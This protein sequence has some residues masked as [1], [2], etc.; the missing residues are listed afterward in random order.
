MLKYNPYLFKLMQSL[1]YPAV[2][3]TF[4]VLFIG[5][6]KIMTNEPWTFLQLNFLYSV[7]LI[8]YF[9]TSFLVNENLSSYKCYN[10]A[11][12]L[13]DFTEIIL[14]FLCFNYLKIENGF[15]SNYSLKYFYLT[16]SLIPFIQ[17]L[18]NISLG[19]TDR[20]YIF[21]DILGILLFLLAGLWLFK[22][23]IFNYLFLF[24]VV[25]LLT[26]YL[27]YLIKVDN[28]WKE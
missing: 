2:L 4:F 28:D 27:Y 9:C 10:A 23:E 12:F 22:F 8:V 6:V 1:L 15:S 3:G 20:V 5:D 24:I 7:V 19:E 25:I 18:W 16:A 21:L 11:N 14:M 17:L 13:L 26:F